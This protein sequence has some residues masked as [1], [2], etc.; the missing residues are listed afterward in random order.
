M[1]WTVLAL[2]SLVVLGGFI[3][4]YGDLQGRRWGKKRVS[5]FGLR[6][7]Y[8][9]V[10]ITSLTGAFVALLSIVTL[11]AVAPAIRNV[12]LQGESAIQDNKALNSQ[13]IDQRLANERALRD[14]N[15][16]LANTQNEFTGLNERYAKLL[17]DMD[18]Q[19]R[20]AKDLRDKNKELDQ[21]YNAQRRTNQTGNSSQP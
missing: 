21:V 9:A 18:K 17:L 5:W 12:V 15:T 13:L 14:L 10:L 8:T 2:I 16:R 3:S 1:F 7:K 19:K 20:L 4:Y 11:L 6:P